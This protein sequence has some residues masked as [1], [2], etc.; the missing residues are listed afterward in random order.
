[1]DDLRYLYAAYKLGSFSID[2]D[3][4]PTTF[5]DYI[6]D[7]LV[8]N[9]D[10]VF[11]V[12]NDKPF[13]MM[14]AISNSPVMTM[15]DVIWFPWATKRNKLEGWLNLLVELKKHTVVTGYTKDKTFFV[16]LSRYGVIRR[17]GTLN[18]KQGSFA[19]FQTGVK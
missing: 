17:I 3:L 9:Y 5:N 13:G 6:E 11:M 12:G 10:Y 8:N 16:H 18:T 14:L 15:Q 2:Q 7:Y 1:M 4:N 19:E